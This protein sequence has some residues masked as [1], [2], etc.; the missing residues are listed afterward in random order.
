MWCDN[1]HA[2][3]NTSQSPVS[4]QEQC[5]ECGNEL[6]AATTLGNQ[7]IAQTAHALL[8]RWEET[9][10][11]QEPTASKEG[12]QTSQPAPQQPVV[13]RVEQPHAPAKPVVSASRSAEDYQNDEQEFEEEQLQSPPPMISR[14][15]TPPAQ[16]VVQKQ[17]PQQDSLPLERQRLANP[18]SFP[19]RAANIDMKPLPK[20]QTPPKAQPSKTVTNSAEKPQAERRSFGKT[21]PKEKSEPTF[22]AGKSAS[23]DA[24]GLMAKA[25]QPEL[26]PRNPS[27]TAQ[28]KPTLEQ[29]LSRPQSEPSMTQKPTVTSVDSSAYREQTPQTESRDGQVRFT[30]RRSETFADFDPETEFTPAKRARNWSAIIGQ[31]LVFCSSLGMTGGIGIIIATRFGAGIDIAESTGWLTFAG[32]HLIFVLGIYTNL[33]S[34]MEQVLNEMHSR[35]DELTRILSYQQTV[36]QNRA[37]PRENTPQNRKSDFARGSLAEELAST[38]PR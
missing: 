33:S 36:S 23:N 21:E 30:P 4:G 1:C 12:D 3:V 18:I 34:R 14:P 5:T 13:R 8:K 35:S 16:P 15:A 28:K 26:S 38:L 27:I 37:M 20:T 7:S 11:D 17:N 22:S 9:R 31:A 32:S 25:R 29:S 24:A 10:Y 2:E 19:K 6:E